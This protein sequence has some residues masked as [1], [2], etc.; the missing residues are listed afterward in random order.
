LFTGALV[1]VLTMAFAGSPYAPF[2]ALAIVGVIYA[3]F[4]AGA[5]WIGFGRV[6]KKALIPQRT[7]EVLKEDKVWLENEAR[8]HL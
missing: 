5:L 2:L 3:A 4:G 7:I 1:A 6:G 8:S